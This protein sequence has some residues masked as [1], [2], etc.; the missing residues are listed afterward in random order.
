MF[1]FGWAVTISNSTGTKWKLFYLSNLIQQLNFFIF[2]NFFEILLF[3][4]ICTCW[5][6]FSYT[7]YHQRNCYIYHGLVLP[8]ISPIPTTINAHIL[9]NNGNIGNLLKYSQQISYQKRKKW[10]EK[11]NTVQDNFLLSMASLITNGNKVNS[12]E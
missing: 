1:P 4:P 11:S 3:L 10:K 2:T 7:L 9:Y 6:I 5:I 8:N 12:F